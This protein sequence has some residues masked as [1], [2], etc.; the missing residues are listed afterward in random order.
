MNPKLNIVVVEDHAALRELTLS[1]LSAE[2][3]TVRGYDS[4]EE[5]YEAGDIAAIDIAV[6]DLNLPG[7]DGLHLA[8]RLRQRHPG[9][10]IVMLTVRYS[11]EHR[12]AGYEHGADI[13]LPKPAASKELIAAVASLARRLARQHPD[14]ADFS[15]L[16][17]DLTCSQLRGPLRSVSLLQSEAALLRAFALAPA[18]ALELWQV[19]QVLG[20]D[21]DQASRMAVA[22]RISRLRKKLIEAGA[23]QPVL[24]AVR[25]Q[26]YRLLAE[27]RLV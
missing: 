19:L 6:L 14:P 4:A 26:G 7:E 22:V 16:S 3:W 11:V 10:G 2:G 20:Q 17:L 18:G 21:P 1:V 15:G 24:R 8:R 5:L 23:H 12:V 27:L 13:Y 25:G 9:V